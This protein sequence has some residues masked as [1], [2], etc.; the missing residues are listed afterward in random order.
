MGLR[1]SGWARTV[2]P[3]ALLALALPAL[4][5][6]PIG[7]ASSA[8]RPN[9]VL[10]L[11]DDLDARSLETAPEHSPNIAALREQGTAFAN[12][13]ITM[14]LCCPSRAS[15]L[16]GQYAHNHGVLNSGGQS[17][18]FAAFHGLDREGS[19]LATWLRDAG[20]RTALLGKYMNGYPGRAAAA[21]YVPPG[22]D[23]WG[24]YKMSVGEEDFS[25]FDYELNENGSLVA[26]GSRPEDYLT[27][28]LAAKAAAFITRSA[29]VGQPFFLCLAPFA[30]HA[31]ATPAP[32][33]AE[34]FP[35]LAAPRVPSLGEVDVSDKPAWVR[36]QVEIGPDEV[37]LIDA[38][39]GLRMR[40]LLAVDDLVAAVTDALRATGTLED[41]YLV[42]TS[43]NGFHLGEHRI[44]YGK[45]TPYEEAIRV[46]LL[47]RG[48][49]VPAGR[50]A[51]ELAL[52][53]DL[54]PTFAEL[55]GAEVPAFVDGRSLVPLLSGGQP[56]AWRQVG[57]VETFERRKDSGSS[58]TSVP[59]FG[60]LR[61]VDLSYVEYA[62]GERELY[63]LRAD[64]YQMENLAES[65]DPAALERLSARLAELRGCAGAGCRAAE[66]A[67]LDL[68][69]D[70]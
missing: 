8:D 37:A 33:H 47:V 45:R 42:F 17:T 44:G 48:P 70:G 11:T 3:L 5:A 66:D 61:T 51:E 2:A 60:A 50:V 54:A 62:T 56:A 10:I 30:P 34:A 65:A 15:I 13:V 32:R 28:V 43:D 38:H 46:P 29:E 4:T 36:D 12:F 16:R 63:D 41:T 40:S 31:P 69:G 9:I 52:N 53:V 27:D 26:Y 58:Q 68:P 24:G 6:D 64:P 59:A 18:G 49:G 67:P 35:G 19:T 25:Y 14:P 1:V 7:A 57:L 23:E 39:H 20:Y 21:T 55:A 22:W